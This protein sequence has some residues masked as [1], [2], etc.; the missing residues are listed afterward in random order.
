MIKSSGC[1]KEGGL[2]W[3]SASHLKDVYGWKRGS[4]AWGAVSS[5]SFALLCS[6]SLNKDGHRKFRMMFS[7]WNVSHALPW[8]F[9]SIPCCCESLQEKQ[10]FLPPYNDQSWIIAA[11]LGKQSREGMSNQ[12]LRILPDT[13]LPVLTQACFNAYHYWDHF[14]FPALTDDNN[15]KKKKKQ[16]EKLLKTSAGFNYTVLCST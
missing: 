11:A 1:F 15:F 4:P 8:L 9:Q 16:A 10:L 7:P 13:S 14:S 5:S 3:E 6:H 12:M 2:C